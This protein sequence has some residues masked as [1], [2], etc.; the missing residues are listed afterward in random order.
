MI[1]F[2]Q[3]QRLWLL[4]LAVLIVL[5]ALPPR[6]QRE[7]LTAHLPQWLRALQRQKRAPLRY[8]WLA[9]LLLLAA[10][11][12]AVVAASRP[13]WPARPGPT[14][15]RVV[16]DASASLLAEPPTSAPG[17]HAWDALT[18][19]MAAG[20]ARLPAHVRAQTEIVRCAGAVTFLRAD[21]ALG[22]PAPR[23]LGM[24]LARVAAGAAASDTA[25][26]TLT[27][28]RAGVPSLGA[29]TVV[30]EPAD[31]AGV[32]ALRVDDRWPL[33]DVEVEV[34]VLCA[35]AAR[36]LGVSVR[37]ADAVLAEPAAPQRCALAAGGRHTLRWSLRRGAGGEV[38][39]ALDDND[40]ALELDDAV[41][42]TLPPPPAPRIAVQ[43]DS[44][45]PVLR[46]AAQS[47]AGETGGE[48]VPATT[49]D[50]RV[51]FV[52]VEGGAQRAADWA[53]LPGITFGTVL[54]GDRAEPAPPALVGQAI[55]WNREHALTAGLDFSELR[56]ARLSA[57]VTGEQLLAHAQ[58]SVAARGQRAVHFAF[59]LADSNL[60]QLPAF[61]QLLRRCYAAAHAETAQVRYAAN[62]LLDAE[63]SELR[64]VSP[65]ADRP[66]PAF[67]APAVDLTRFFALAALVFLAARVLC[68]RG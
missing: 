5:L 29:L 10:F 51:S 45:A 60:W 11:L 63:E 65:V 17:P 46:I 4:G 34:D 38:I 24:D 50:A 67:G 20:L 3:A 14:K 62:N 56:I 23:A 25:T 47:L 42:F 57:A 43:S 18:R 19:A 15:L 54:L 31:N 22:E 41:A 49:P 2:A 35:G 32:V 8:P 9:M 36:E 55:E 64:H 39:L 66:L 21:A 40:D 37:S 27:D 61:P 48:V 28:G 44:D 30:G 59:R 16:V 7:V 68:S 26:W 1:E 6:P 12:A 13:R 33:P 58:T 52:L 53:D